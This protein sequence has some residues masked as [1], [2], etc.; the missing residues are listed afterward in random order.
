MR[1]LYQQS[2]RVHA[3]TFLVPCA[4]FSLLFLVAHPSLAAMECG[5]SSCEVGEFCS[6]ET[7]CLSCSECRAGRDGERLSETSCFDSCTT[8]VCPCEDHETCG[9]DGYCASCDECIYY[10][11][12]APSAEQCQTQSCYITD[13]LP[14]EPCPYSASPAFGAPIIVS[15][16]E[17]EGTIS[18]LHEAIQLAN[19]NC[20]VNEIILQ[21][22][23]LAIQTKLPPI[24]SPVIISSPVGTE[25]ALV[26]EHYG[27]DGLRI[28]AE[29]FSLTNVTMSGFSQ[30]LV[31]YSSGATVSQFHVVRCV[32]G[33]RLTS[34][35]RYATLTD[36]T[37]TDMYSNP[38]W[39]SGYFHTLENVVVNGGGG[40]GITVRS[41]AYIKLTSCQ[42]S[43][44]FA[45][46]L[47]AS[48]V[49]DLTVVGGYY[50]VAPF[51]SQLP[52]T[53]SPITTTRNSNSEAILNGNTLAGISMTRVYRAVVR[54]VVVAGNSQNGIT[55]ISSEVITLTRS[56]VGGDLSQSNS[57]YNLQLED[58]SDILVGGFATEGNQFFGNAGSLL[59]HIRAM[60]TDSL[61]ISGNQFVAESITLPSLGDGVYNDEVYN[62]G[63]YAPGGGILNGIY[64]EECSN[65]TVGA[66]TDA[67]G[68]EKGNVFVSSACNSEL[69]LH[70]CVNVRVANNII[71]TN[72]SRPSANMDAESGAL[73][74][75]ASTVVSF[76]SVQAFDVVR[77]YITAANADAALHVQDC[78]NGGFSDNVI[79]EAPDAFIK[80]GVRL[81]GGS[82]H[83][84]FGPNNRVH[85]SDTA[86]LTDAI[87]YAY[88]EGLPSEDI[89]SVLLHGNLICVNADASTVGNCRIGVN[90]SATCDDVQLGSESKA[91]NSIFGF[92]IAVAA[93]GIAD[94][95]NNHIGVNVD[96]SIA[97][98]TPTTNGDGWNENLSNPSQTASTSPPASGE[99]LTEEGFQSPHGGEIGLQAPSGARVRLISKNVIGG[100]SVAG[101]LFS[102]VVNSNAGWPLSNNRIGVNKDGTVAIPNYDGM[103]IEQ[104]SNLDISKNVVSGNARYGVYVRES[105]YLRIES[106][107][108]GTNAAGRT[109]IPNKAHGMKIDSSSQLY[110]GTASQSTYSFYP[111]GNVISGNLG[112]GLE[113]EGGYDCEV[114]HNIIG[115]R[116]TGLLALANSMSG[117]HILQ[118]DH[119]ALTNNTISGNLIDG[120]VVTDSNSTSF[121]ANRI[122]TSL[123]GIVAQANGG[124]GVRVESGAR[125]TL[126][127]RSGSFYAYY[128]EQRITLPPN[129]VSGNKMS[130]LYDAGEATR[131]EDGYFG[132][133]ST[134]E[135]RLA[136]RMHGME[137]RGTNTKIGRTAEG[138]D[139][140]Y[141]YYDRY[142]GSYSSADYYDYYFGELEVKP[143]VVSGNVGNGIRIQDAANIQLAAVLVGL[144][145]SGTKTIANQLSGVLIRNSHNVFVG[146]VPVELIDTT[147]TAYPSTL[148][149]TAMDIVTESSSSSSSTSST[150][151]ETPFPYSTQSTSAPLVSSPSTGS[152]TCTPGYYETVPATGTTDR[153]CEPC[154]A[155]TYWMNGT[156]LQCPNGTYAA[157]ASTMCESCADMQLVDDDNDP[158][159]PCTSPRVRRAPTGVRPDPS[160]LFESNPALS[161]HTFPTAHSS[162]LSP[163][164]AMQQLL[165][166]RQRLLRQRLLEEHESR[167]ASAAKIPVA[168]RTSQGLSVTLPSNVPGH[169]REGQ[170]PSQT[171]QL[172]AQH[173]QE[174]G[175]S[176][177]RRALDFP[178]YVIIASNGKDGIE[179]VASG[180]VTIQGVQ[181]GVTAQDLKR[182]NRR[183]G[184][185]VSQNS[186]VTIGGSAGGTLLVLVAH[187]AATGL[188][189]ADSDVFFRSVGIFD[190]ALGSVVYSGGLVSMPK[191]PSIQIALF[192]ETS[193]QAIVSVV[194]PGP[195]LIQVYAAS[196][197]LARSRAGQAERLITSVVQTFDDPVSKHVVSLAW[198]SAEATVADGEVVTASIASL[199]DS[200]LISELA[201]CRGPERDL[202]L[203]SICICYA[204]TA[205]C[206]GLLNVAPTL[207]KTTN[208]TS[209]YLGMN[210]VTRFPTNL[211][212]QLPNLELLDVAEMPN[213][214]FT[215][216]VLGQ[217]SAL[218]SLQHLNLS[219]NSLTSLTGFD[220]PLSLV[221]LDLSGNMFATNPISF[222]ANSSLEVLTLDD[223]LFEVLNMNEFYGATSLLGLSIRNNYFVSLEEGA[224]NGLVSLQ[225]LDLS[226]AFAGNAT[227]PAQI[228]AGLR[229]LIAVNWLT[230]GCP[231]GYV[232][233]FTSGG[234]ICLP[235]PPGSF[236]TGGNSGSLVDCRACPAGYTD[237]D[238]DSVTDCVPCMSG[239]Y[240]PVGSYG[241]CPACA[242]GTVDHDGD[243][244]SPCR[245]CPEGT[246][247]NTTTRQCESCQ[248]NMSDEDRFSGTPCTVC[249]PGYVP[250]DDHIGACLLDAWNPN[251][252]SSSNNNT[253]IIVGVVLGIAVVIILIVLLVAYR[254][255]QRLKKE[256][257]RALQD[258]HKSAKVEFERLLSKYDEGRKKDA[259]AK[260]DQMQISRDSFATLR[261]LGAGEYGVVELGEMA[262]DRQRVAIKRLH[263]K[264]V[265]ADEQS[266]FLQEARL[267]A[268]LEHPNIVRLLGVCTLETPFLMVLEFLPGGDLRGFLKKQAKAKSHASPETLTMACINIAQAMAYLEQNHIVHRDLAARNVLVGSSLPDVKLADFG[269]S[270]PLDDKDYY[271]KESGDRVPMKWM[272]PESIRDKT[273][274]H[275]S[276]V[277][278]FGILCWEIFSFG[279]MP[280]PGYQALEAIVAVA[281]GYRMPRP[282][283]CPNSVYD[284]VSMMWYANASDRPTFSELIK[285][286]QDALENIDVKKIPVPPRS[287]ASTLAKTDPRYRDW[288]DVK[289]ENMLTPSSVSHQDAYVGDA[290][291][292]A[293]STRLGV[294]ELPPLASRTSTLPSSA[295]KPEEQKETFGLENQLSVRSRSPVLDFGRGL[296][297]S[298]DTDMD[299]NEVN[300]TEPAHKGGRLV[301]NDTYEQR[302]M[303]S[304]VERAYVDFMEVTPDQAQ[305]ARTSD[306]HEYLEVGA[307][308]V[309]LQRDIPLSELEPAVPPRHV[310]QHGYLDPTGASEVLNTMLPSVSET[311]FSAQKSSVSHRRAEEE[312]AYL[313]PEI[314]PEVMPRRSLNK[315]D[316]P[317]EERSYMDPVVEFPPTAPRLSRNTDAK[318]SLERAYLEPTTA[319]EAVSRAM[320]SQ[321][322]GSPSMP[323]RA[324]QE[325]AHPYL[326]LMSP[327][328]VELSSGL[329]NASKMEEAR[330]QSL[331]QKQQSDKMPHS[332]SMHEF[333]K[334]R[335]QSEPAILEQERLK[336]SEGDKKGT[337]I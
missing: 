37:A 119:T 74:S 67:D 262:A 105:N 169:T 163:Q 326:D 270:R 27:L 8:P 222:P 63:Y 335:M 77:N 108:V 21:V 190:N 269:M 218:T 28:H 100:F 19:A 73:F 155:G 306:P 12:T 226:T 90:I 18:S 276:D 124:H 154:A 95:V 189:V 157:S 120:V 242:M 238:E 293:S 6:G 329:F 26:G 213:V 29:P 49:V 236:P 243:P 25:I 295:S 305:S 3:V 330:Q 239:T 246:F 113:I 148:E 43:S 231:Q 299:E 292:S 116:Q 316:E 225:V 115:L 253:G 267:M 286:L 188:L 47:D 182:G 283:Y 129:L 240:T 200:S 325:E 311:H 159:T 187:N 135:A 209:L 312:R 76:S 141:Y 177:D 211:L 251:A 62:G 59:S 201:T 237:D 220:L 13:T 191:R 30:A 314:P 69:R 192:D 85:A 298:T 96:G 171:S 324:E 71:G 196:S 257:E 134:G 84:T 102:N 118:S 160:D 277:W 126:F 245:V 121:L 152:T 301:S 321:K 122:G 212:N 89:Y 87:Y 70:S 41:A 38:I 42:V 304:D 125:D 11:T 150:F 279:Q 4:L 331:H 139:T 140:Y 215:P 80:Q 32:E 22:Q 128:N 268:I 94:I 323:A 181:I 197:C 44:A 221:S 261:E 319:S 145:V 282:D 48:R 33:I 235:C 229:N 252:N 35:S 303:L 194:E 54:N 228:L 16:T 204:S 57:P 174:H 250:P 20:D 151:R 337:I 230:A 23:T 198:S 265:D 1:G 216:T 83:M 81:E 64:L 156:C 315:R 58:S 72:S 161:H 184:I 99:T 132:V 294:S 149:T 109:A 332:A 136:N 56:R 79:L 281:G 103:R 61:V 147:T 123:T 310:K 178:V 36:I 263:A 214:E 106:N 210:D 65:V 131:V 217:I 24:T 256:K 17:E 92:A 166:L 180:M 313:E 45:N 260:F 275:A 264:G 55:I 170:P 2:A 183:N 91:P 266:K 288:D 104:C 14:H 138:E 333:R 51:S 308:D 334:S 97:L 167:L 287:H 172:E 53:T 207:V 234:S 185:N 254:K 272:S 50:G 318:S 193:A 274:T 244:A 241:S 227:W 176:R 290:P 175:L 271:R 101:I 195:Y 46:G 322:S 273:S 143:A 291:R 7:S 39:I 60:Q 300:E 259:A 66:Q 75:S 142:T 146:S 107:L 93:Q 86:I 68:Y 232:A 15:D 117:V 110:V 203:C 173:T 137:L 78:F 133:D 205:D 258:I 10:N 112:Y 296:L 40:N 336:N 9:T 328:V 88:H 186:Q 164:D 223:N 206:R 82:S 302:R 202:E 327:E 285:L 130:G 162:I 31:I 153:Y 233:A 34:S 320:A 158:S 199:R 168:S 219:S 247:A 127:V 307:N 280:Y 114:L 255:V 5:S 317:V 249:L 224:F 284:V 111:G 289:R 309:R 248:G 52:S 144:G 165:I 179:V 98:T 208:I 297:M 278:S